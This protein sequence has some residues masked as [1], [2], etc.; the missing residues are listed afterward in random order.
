MRELKP[1][2]DGDV[3]DSLILVPADI[4]EQERQEGLRFTLP[5]DENLRTFLVEHF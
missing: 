1:V 4:T 5:L 2:L 3:T